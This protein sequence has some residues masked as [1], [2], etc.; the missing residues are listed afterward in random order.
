MFVKR[1]MLFTKDQLLLKDWV[2]QAN[3]DGLLNE[4]QKL[5]IVLHY[6]LKN[7]AIMVR[8]ITILEICVAELK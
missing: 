2:K 1:L 7:L 8:A 6:N 3:I 4:L 5:Q